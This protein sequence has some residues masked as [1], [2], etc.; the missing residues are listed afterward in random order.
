MVGQEK[1]YDIFEENRKLKRSEHLVRIESLA[2]KTGEIRYFEDKAE[3][4]AK[5]LGEELESAFDV[6]EAILIR[7]NKP[8]Y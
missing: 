4:F 6:E 2:V 3:G 8:G 7:E 5:R 1:T